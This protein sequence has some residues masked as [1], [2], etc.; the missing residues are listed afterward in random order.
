MEN[1]QSLSRFSRRFRI[2]AVAALPVVA[3]LILGALESGDAVLIYND[4]PTLLA[5]IQVE[6]EAQRWLVRD[7]EPRESRRL[8][9][10]A[11]H[12]ADVAIKVTDWEGEPAF[13]VPTDWRSASM[14]TVRLNGS[15]TITATTAIAFWQR[16]LN[17]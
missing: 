14:V 8:R 10:H 6:V 11:T 4:G 7:L 9:V 15:R 5:E 1:Y 12:A 3:A 16:W 2:A 17:W 13:H